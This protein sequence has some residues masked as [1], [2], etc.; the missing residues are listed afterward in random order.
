MPP[1]KLRVLDLLRD[2]KTYAA[3]AEALGVTRRDL[4]RMR[5]AD[6]AFS[7]ACDEAQLV[8]TDAAEDVLSDCAMN[9]INNPKH[10]TSLIF[11][12]KNRRP[13]KWRDVSAVQHGLD[14]SGQTA[15]A[16]AALIQ[17]ANDIEG[18]GPR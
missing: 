14:T 13:Q 16:L 1:E 15:D 17:Q 3:C 5:V 10:Q 8:G 6:P 4:Y 12:L 2:G 18:G 11:L 7:A 9:A